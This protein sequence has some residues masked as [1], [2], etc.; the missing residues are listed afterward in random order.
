ML[1]GQQPSD[2]SPE[3]LS[4]ARALQVAPILSMAIKPMFEQ[5]WKKKKL[6]GEISKAKWARY[7]VDADVIHL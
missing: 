5:L 7:F 3:Q 2:R 4:R 1:L 6:P